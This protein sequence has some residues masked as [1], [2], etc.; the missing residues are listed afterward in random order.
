MLEKLAARDRM[1]AS[2]LR[3]ME[4]YHF[5]LWPACGVAAF[6][7][8]QRSWTTPAREIDYFEAMIPLTT[9]NLLGLPAMVVPFSFNDDGMPVGIQLIGRPYEE[10]RLLELAVQLEEARGFFL[11]PDGY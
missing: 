10:E 2:L 6:N 11:S 4:Q 5:L 7:H 9:A 8:R 3:Q 1:R